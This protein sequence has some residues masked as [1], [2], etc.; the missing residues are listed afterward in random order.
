ML[1]IDEALQRFQK[2]KKKN[3]ENTK[4]RRDRDKI[5]AKLRD[6]IT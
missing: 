5:F 3:W 2:L 6:P 4:V 1:I